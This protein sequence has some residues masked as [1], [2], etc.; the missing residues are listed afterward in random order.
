METPLIFFF[1]LLAGVH[2]V[3]SVILVTR[4]V[5]QSA[6]I[7][8]SYDKQYGSKS[9][10]LCRGECPVIGGKDIPIST[11]AGQTKAIKG[12]FSLHDDTTAGVFTVTITGLTEGDSGQYWCGVKTRFAKYDQYTEVELK[13]QKVLPPSRNSTFMPSTEDH[14]HSSSTLTSN[15][16]QTQHVFDTTISDNASK[17]QLTAADL[18][19]KPE[20]SVVIVIMCLLVLLLMVCGLVSALFYRQRRRKLTPECGSSDLHNSDHAGEVSDYERTDEL[21]SIP[22]ARASVSSVYCLAGAPQ[23]P[24]VI[25]LYSTIKHVKQ[26]SD[27]PIYCNSKQ[28]DVIYSN[29]IPPQVTTSPTMQYRPQLTKPLAAAGRGVSQIGRWINRWI[30]R[31]EVFHSV[32]LRRPEVTV[33]LFIHQDM[34][35][36]LILFYGL[37]AGVY[38]VESVITV[39]GYVGRSVGIRCPYDRGYDGYSKYLCKGT[40]PRMG[41]KDIPIRT[42]ADQ[43]KAINGR[44][45]LH[46]KT[47]A[48]VFTVTITG[49]S[50]E[51]SGQYWCGVK[52][53]FGRYDVLTELK[54]DVLPVPP[55][56]PKSTTTE[57]HTLSSSSSSGPTVNTSQF[58]LQ[59]STGSST[60]ACP[61][62]AG[63]TPEPP[64]GRVSSPVVLILCVV[65]LLA[66]ALVC[67][68]AY[69][70]R[71]KKSK[72][73]VP[74]RPQNGGLAEEPNDYEMT[75]EPGSAPEPRQSVS[76]LYCLADTPL[77]P[78]GITT[79][80]PVRKTPELPIYF[81]SEEDTGFPIY[82]NATA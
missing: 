40:C 15:T 61:W 30:W 39:T 77:R 31:G 49:L 6:V 9:K 66:V 45:S 17:D 27:Q 73:N 55:L 76:T 20:D 80:R 59:P 44:F 82:A 67:G 58:D 69:R 79:G 24:S 11:E 29:V 3:E 51:D 62:A 65:G 22:A 53:G 28:E 18:Q 68:L 7:R 25:S 46:D 16:S 64:E 14:T 4:Y 43:T 50:A 54:L 75:E 36:P 38:P 56:S 63:E 42:E 74:P 47:T 32:T 33:S 13:V 52:T 60:T 35:T 37:L 71:G 19:E 12:R 21:G 70:L 26:G 72:G 23:R 81:N 8:C 1:C 10:Y 34:K 57:D 48:G 2:P 41:G 5:G 78:S